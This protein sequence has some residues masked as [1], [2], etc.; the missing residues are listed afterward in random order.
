MPAPK[1][2][3]QAFMGPRENYKCGALAI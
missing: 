2:G 1:R 3:D